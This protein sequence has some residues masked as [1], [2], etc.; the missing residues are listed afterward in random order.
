[1][2]KYPS[3][4]PRPWPK[5]PNL[6][7]SR[8]TDQQKMDLYNRVITTRALAKELG[9]HERYLSC[10]FPHKVPIVDKRVMT[11]AR[12]AHRL[13]IAVEVLE[14]KYTI[15]EASKIAHVSYTTMQRYVGKAKDAHPDLARKFSTRR[16]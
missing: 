12:R 13:A 11:E 16:V 6:L 3:S 9:V 8:I 5:K 15:G 14:G 10:M 7:Q 2:E 1:M 4:W